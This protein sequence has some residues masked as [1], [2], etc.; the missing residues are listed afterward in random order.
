M[1]H[2]S[3]Y[4]KD[5][6]G[7]GLTP[8]NSSGTIN[9]NE[10]SNNECEI[11]EYSISYKSTY[12]IYNK[13]TAFSGI[14]DI[15][16]TG[17]N[18]K[19]E[20]VK[21]NITLKAIKIYDK[22]KK[23][24]Y[25]YSLTGELD[26]FNPGAISK[27]DN[28]ADN[29]INLNGKK[30]K[31][32][33]D[34]PGSNITHISVKIKFKY[35]L[36]NGKYTKY[37][38]KKHYANISIKNNKWVLEPQSADQQDIIAVDAIRS[39]YEQEL[40]LK[41]KKITID[42]GSYNI[43]LKK[44][45][46]TTGTPLSGATFAIQKKIKDSKT[47][48]F[49]EYGSVTRVTTGTDGIINIADEKITKS[50]YNNTVRYKIVEET[51]PSMHKKHD[52][53]ILVD[54]TK[55]LDKANGRYE[56]DSV[57]VY[58]GL[59]QMKEGDSKKPVT[60]QTTPRGGNTNI[61]VTV[62]NPQVASG[63]FDLNLQKITAGT[64]STK[65]HGAKFIIKDE[66]NTSTEITEQEDENGGT[67]NYNLLKDQSIEKVGTYTYYIT[68]KQAPTNPSACVKFT[69]KIKVEVKT[70]IGT[71]T[72]NDKT[73]YK[74]IVESVNVK[75]FDSNNNELKENNSPVSQTNTTNG[76]KECT[77]NLKMTNILEGS[78]DLKIN[79]ISSSSGEPLSGA[80]FKIQKATMN[81]SGTW[82]WDNGTTVSTEAKDEN[83]KKIKRNICTKE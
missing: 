74:Y 10:T 83:G 31:L 56:V 61:T 77:I 37:N 81:S 47:G 64:T 2:Y 63:K 22:S 27:I 55:K 57:V 20:N 75:A 8:Q 33:F 19:D 21:K 50:N 43:K 14:S 60:Y 80:K 73:T 23:T 26:F 29:N 18:D 82:T 72:K 12:E 7:Y 66:N 45:E 5:V 78:Y 44:V 65:L 76:N 13:E 11:G 46:E 32:V 16:I 40:D 48:K 28:D 53:S 42:N 49:G 34:N 25:R 51:P 39:V 1:V 70:G 6:R 38:G 71:I 62:S 4:D 54:V 9:F 24:W 41:S 36:A 17:T 68:E 67:G 69:G 15:I 52:Q 30:F 3:N 35:M 79:K 59:V 58:D